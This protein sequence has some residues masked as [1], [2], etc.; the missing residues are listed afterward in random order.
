VPAELEAV[1]ALLKGQKN[2]AR[3]SLAV[4]RR[5]VLRDLTAYVK[6]PA[7]KFELRFHW[8]FRSVNQPVEV[9]AL[10]GEKNRP[11]DALL[12]KFGTDL[13]AA[14]QANGREVVLGFLEGL[15]AGLGGRVS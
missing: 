12:R 1:G 6:L 4:D 15:G 13:E 10:T 7:P 14:M 5:G 9:Y 3:A 2:E 8:A 11:V